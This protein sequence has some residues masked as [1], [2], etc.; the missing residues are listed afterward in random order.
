[1]IG[2]LLTSTA[3]R[4][5]EMPVVLKLVDTLNDGCTGPPWGPTTMLNRSAH[6]H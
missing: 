4:I 6:G 2:G 1:M 3:L 5:L